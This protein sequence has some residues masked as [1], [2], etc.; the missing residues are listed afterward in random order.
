MGAYTQVIV[1]FSE[2]HL[3]RGYRQADKHVVR[4]RAISL[5]MNS[6]HIVDG[7]DV[8]EAENIVNHGFR[9]VRLSQDSGILIAR[10]EESVSGGEKQDQNTRTW[11]IPRRVDCG[12]GSE[13]D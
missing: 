10:R 8:R 2:E 12:A 7:I 11:Q 6:Y 5:S 9:L 13:G 3:D 1:T 4:L